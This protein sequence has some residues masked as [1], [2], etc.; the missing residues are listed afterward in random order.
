[1]SRAVLKETFERVLL[2]SFSCA[3]VVNARKKTA[4]FFYSI[5][6]QRKPLAKIRRGAGIV[7]MIFQKEVF[8]VY[9]TKLEIFIGNTKNKNF[10]L[11]IF[12]LKK[13]F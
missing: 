6:L 7:G 11:Y 9:R 13:T 10:Y 8:A 4:S 2:P 5:G 3:K 12:I 1:L